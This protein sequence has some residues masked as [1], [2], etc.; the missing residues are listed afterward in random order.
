MKRK[1]GQES[2]RV[3]S[4]AF[5]QNTCQTFVNPNCAKNKLMKSLTVNRA[6]VVAVRED[7]VAG[8]EDSSYQYQS[9][10]H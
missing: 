2:K 10:K 4:L 1:V 3:E 6:L 9:Q 7:T 8:I 5:T